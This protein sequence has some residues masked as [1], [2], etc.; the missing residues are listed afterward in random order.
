[1][2]LAD[3]LEMALSGPNKAPLA[4]KTLS[5]F[6]FSSNGIINAAQIK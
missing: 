2:F 1:V 6:D 4:R 3:L 5:N